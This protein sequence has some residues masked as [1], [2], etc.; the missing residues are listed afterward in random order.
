MGLCDVDVNTMILAGGM[1][2]EKASQQRHLHEL[3]VTDSETSVS[4]PS[5][6]LDHMRIHLT[7]LR[8]RESHYKHV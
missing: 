2:I 8:E 6:Y 3:Y 1:S 5:D 4:K 7:V